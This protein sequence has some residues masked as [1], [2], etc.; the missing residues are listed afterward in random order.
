MA[1]NKKLKKMNNMSRWLGS[2]QIVYIIIIIA[3]ILLLIFG[4]FLYKK[5]YNT[6]IQ[7]ESCR[8]SCSSS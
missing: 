2:N 5:L 4:F 6:K 8:S 3:T 1:Q 7:L